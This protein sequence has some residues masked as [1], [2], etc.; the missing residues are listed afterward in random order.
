MTGERC[1][2]C[3]NLKQ[4]C[5]C[6][7]S[8]PVPVEVFN[9]G[10]T[11]ETLRLA[12]PRPDRESG[13][14]LGCGYCD[15]AWYVRNAEVVRVGALCDR[16]PEPNK[17]IDDVDGLVTTELGWCGC[18]NPE[19]VDE[20]MLRFLDSFTRRDDTN[21]EH[22]ILPDENDPWRHAWMLLAYIADDL[23]WTEHGGSIYGSWLTENGVRAR[24]NLRVAVAE[25]AE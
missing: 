19:D 12:V 22:C 3:F 9:H 11:S 20:M 5:T 1:M 15:T 21:Y 25:F 17:D 4:F 2:V 10:W 18:G 6:D 13:W 24:E 23:H 14:F 7:S 16:C 8:Q